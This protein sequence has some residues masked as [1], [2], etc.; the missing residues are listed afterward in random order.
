MN[1]KSNQTNRHRLN[2][3]SQACC[4]ANPTCPDSFPKFRLMQVGF[5]HLLLRPEVSNECFVGHRLMTTDVMRLGLTVVVVFG[6]WTSRLTQISIADRP[7][8][9]LSTAAIA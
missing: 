4:S 6:N 8:P 7:S 9:R 2:T 1:P 5:R 3:V